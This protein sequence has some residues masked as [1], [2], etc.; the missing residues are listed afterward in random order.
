MGEIQHAALETRERRRDGSSGTPIR[1]AADVHQR[2]YPPEDLAAFL[3][4]DGHKEAC[5]GGYG[6]VEGDVEGSLVVGHVVPDGL[7]VR[8]P[9]RRQVRLPV[10][11][12]QRAHHG[13]ERRGKQRTEQHGQE[14]SQARG[15]ADPVVVVAEEETGGC[16]QLIDRIAAPPTIVWCG[17]DGDGWT[18]VDAEGTC[19]GEHAHEA[20]Q[21][22]ALCRANIDLG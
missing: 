8:D 21:A 6:V 13:G 22:S 5:V 14:R 7:S 15:V 1:S 11:P 19:D 4:D 16:R 10:L 17:G 2:V 18:L 12:D 3:E 9:E 20:M